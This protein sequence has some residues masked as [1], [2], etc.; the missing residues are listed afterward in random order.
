M[1][2]LPDSRSVF[3]T[4]TSL[5]SRQRPFGL[6][7]G[8]G[9]LAEIRAVR[10]HHQPCRFGLCVGNR[11]VDRVVGNGDVAIGKVIIAAEFRARA[12][13]HRD[14]VAA[15]AAVPTVRA[16]EHIARIVVAD[17][18]VALGNGLDTIQTTGGQNQI[19][20]GEG[21]AVL[22]NSGA[23]DTVNLGSISPDQLWFSQ[24]GQNLVV[25]VL[26]SPESLTV[27][28]WFNGATNQVD[29]F[30]ANGLTLSNSGVAH[31]VQAMAAYPAPSAG[32]TSYT[33]QEQ[34][35]LIPLVTSSWK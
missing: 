11:A 21:Q 19:R 2:T 28:G 26:G 1:F 13:I 23:A 8:I 29:S 22:N 31:L 12:A 33:A 7:G 9:D 4:P 16:G 15:A 34:Q 10:I 18:D 3:L 6:I 24:S 30:S 17:A 5:S 20:L 25:D 14:G 32:Q 35:T 27:Q